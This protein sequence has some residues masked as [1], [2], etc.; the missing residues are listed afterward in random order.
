MRTGK[1]TK[2]IIPDI[3]RKIQTHSGKLTNPWQNTQKMT[4]RQHRNTKHKHPGPHWRVCRSYG[5]Y[6]FNN[7]QYI[8]FQ[9]F[10]LKE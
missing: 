7:R 8:D 6:R 4:L 3:E 10:M 2:N 9:I 5:I 1:V